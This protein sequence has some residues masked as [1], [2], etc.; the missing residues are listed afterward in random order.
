MILETERLVLRHFQPSD[1]PFIVE[2]LNDPGWLLHIGDRGVHTLQQAV[3]Y[4][5]DGPMSMYATYGF[6]LY[7]VERKTDQVPIGMCGLVKRG[8]LEDVDIGFAFLQRYQGQGYSFEAACSV[9]DYAAS[10][11]G[12]KRLVAITSKDNDRSARLLGKLGFRFER[13]I[14]YA[15]D[16]DELRLFGRSLLDSSN[17]PVGTTLRQ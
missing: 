11:L 14:S 13:M 4:I 2:L 8:F 10:T 12:L 9:Q 5:Q 17:A 1:A 6:G 7:H 3:D 15:D 16:G